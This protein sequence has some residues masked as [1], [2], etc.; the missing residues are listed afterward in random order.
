MVVY[1]AGS[2]AIKLRK[3]GGQQTIWATQAEIAKLYGKDQSVVSRHIA[4]IFHDGE[5]HK[6][7][8]MQEMHIANSDKPVA[9]YG[10][11]IILA[12][13]YRTN[14]RRAI[15][16]RK[17]ATKTLRQYVIEGYV[18]DKKR[19]LRNYEQFSKTIREI[20]ELLPEGV[21]ADTQSVLELISAFADTWLSLDAYDKGKLAAHGATRKRVA[22]TA[23]KLTNGL[24]G[25]KATLLEK[26]K[27]T[28]HFGAE[29]SPEQC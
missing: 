5:V 7:S 15:E 4:G 29:R 11:D 12:V 25:L 9:F 14:S 13:G 23:E 16:F 10:L 24:A 8:N 2:G 6:K 26:G 18:V 20:R 27:A 28:A 3:D 22:L 21:A 1:Q 17:W 19:V